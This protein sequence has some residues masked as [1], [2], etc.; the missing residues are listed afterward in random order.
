MRAVTYQ[1]RW[2]CSS[3]SAQGSLF[4]S[5]H[6]NLITVHHAIANH[7]TLTMIALWNKMLTIK[8][9]KETF[10]D[11]I[12][13]LFLMY[14]NFFDL[15]DKAIIDS[16]AEWVWNIFYKIIHFKAICNEHDFLDIQ[17]EK[18][19]FTRIWTY[20]EKRLKVL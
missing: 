13:L 7:C 20:E 4:S 6:W 3:T 8:T 5:S 1:P 18:Q 15:D 10:Y 11:I 9:L 17:W 2:Q 19:T 14:L 16:N 12:I